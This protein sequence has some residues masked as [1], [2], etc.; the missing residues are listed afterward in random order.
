MVFKESGGSMKIYNKVIIDI[1]TGKTLYKD[2]YT[3]YGPIIKLKGDVNVPGPSQAEIELQQQQTEMLQY[4]QSLLEQMMN[5]QELLSPILYEQMGIT[6][7]YN[8]AGDIVGFDYTESELKQI[9]DEINQLTAEQTLQA[10]KGELPVSSTVE[11]EIAKGEEALRQRLA[12]SLG[13]GYETSSPGI[14][15]LNKFQESATN[16]REQASKGQLSMYEQL[17]LA[18]QAATQ[19]ANTDFFSKSIGLA[20][21]PSMG[22]T[23][24]NSILGNIANAISGYQA[25]R[26][27][28]LQANIAT[29]QNQAQTW[30]SIFG[31]LGSAIGTAGGLYALGL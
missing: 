24:G 2:S 25:N 21:A 13:P 8:D 16:I 19:G 5:Q 28:G 26:Q 17:G 6:P 10:L 12:K 11:T 3:W 29:A 14:E 7:Q 18:Q 4:Q 20:T 9:T 15:A 30:Q 27:M 23:G 31:G 1:E 22:I